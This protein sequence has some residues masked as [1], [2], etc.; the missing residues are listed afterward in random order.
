[1]INEKK[2]SL[3]YY[4]IFCLITFLIS[5]YHIQS[6]FLNI[7]NKIK[8]QASNTSFIISEWIKSS[9]EA[10]DYILRDMVYTIPISAL[11]YPII[12]KSEHANITKYIE[13]KQKTVPYSNGVGLSDKDCIVTHTL[14]IVGFNGSE[15]EWCKG[16]KEHKDRDTYISNMFVSNNGDFM[17]MQGRKFPSDEYLGQAGIGINLRFFSEF[18]QKVQ[19]GEN[20]ILAIFDE[21]QKLLA[22]QPSLNEQLGK[23]INSEALNNF[24]IS[25]DRNKLVSGV[26]PLDDEKRIYSFQKVDNTPFIVVV[27]ETNKGWQKEWIEELWKSSIFLIIQWFIAFVALRLYWNKLDNFSELTKAYSLVEKMSIT[28]SLT[29]L[30]NRGY[31]DMILE[32]EFRRMFR[33]K[34]QIS[35][36]MIDIDYFKAYNDTYGHLKGDD[37]LKTIASIMNSCIKRPQDIIA[38]YGGEEFVCVLPQTD[39]AGAISIASNIKN[40]IES[41]NIPHKNS[42]V[43][44]H[45][46]ISIGI[47]TSICDENI[48]EKDIL[49]IADKNLYKAKENGRNQVFSN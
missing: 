33:T 42:K 46:T 36:I 48:T 32:K 17:V 41:M 29:G 13:D 9:F 24:I 45:I 12:N 22:R 23:K 34:D 49:K 28:D 47:A 6:T 38:R 19:V 20:S 43:A 16:L 18:L 4:L 11:Q 1:M 39:K 5:Y 2:K 27:G 30:Y 15:R 8:I 14:S 44:K 21:N 3:F 7:Q 10:T 35:I 26:S 37:C 40:S 31:F 25:K